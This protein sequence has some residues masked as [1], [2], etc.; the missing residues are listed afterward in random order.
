MAIG[1][2]VLYSFGLFVLY[3]LLPMIPAVVLFW[4][5]PD[6]KVAV[7]GPLQN[8][9]VKATGAFGAYVITVALGFVLVRYVET[10]IDGSRNYAVEGVIADLAPNQCID[11]DQFYSRYVTAASDPTGELQTRDYDFVVLL[12]HPVVKPETVYLKYWQLNA[13]AGTGPAPAPIDIAMQLVA[14]KQRYRLLIQN[15]QPIIEPESQVT[16]KTASD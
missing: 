3:V 8:L 2:P 13:S 1:N 11:S 10:Q 16:A 6:S 5:F 15:N 12:N 7:S 14:T 9:T 4:L